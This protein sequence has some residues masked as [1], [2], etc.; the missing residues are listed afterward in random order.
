MLFE[1]VER[2]KKVIEAIN[3]YN[4]YDNGKYSIAVDNDRGGRFR[5]IPYFKFCKSTNFSTSKY[6]AR[7]PIRQVEGKANNGIEYQIHKNGTGKHFNLNNKEFDILEEML[8]SE[9]DGKT[10]WKKIIE[11]SNEFISM[12]DK[13]LIIDPNSPIPDYRNLLKEI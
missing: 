1:W 11:V 13:T 6:I 8:M 12:Y 7:I 9:T 5:Y 2:N 10:V 4:I 3:E